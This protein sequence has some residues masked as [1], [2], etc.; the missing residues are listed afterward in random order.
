M[1]NDRFIPAFK[2]LAHLRKYEHSVLG[3]LVS[4]TRFY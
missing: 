3:S 4:S 1:R 2:K